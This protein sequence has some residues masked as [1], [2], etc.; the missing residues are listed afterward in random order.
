MK[1]ATLQ[2]L[3]AELHKAFEDDVVDIDHVKQLMQ[4]Y[5]TDPA[6]WRQYAKFDRYR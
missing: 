1:V 5:K 3:I 2:D 4:A 6:E